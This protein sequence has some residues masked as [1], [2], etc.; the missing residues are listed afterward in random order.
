MINLIHLFA[1][2]SN[3]VQW[4]WN[5]KIDSESRIWFVSLLSWF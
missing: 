4:N 1:P 3:L 2:V 5:V